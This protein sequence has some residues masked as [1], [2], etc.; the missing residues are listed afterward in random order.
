[1]IL[2]ICL[3][4]GFKYCYFL[5]KWIHV[6]LCNTSSSI[7]TVKW[8]QLLL[9]PTNNS[10][11]TGNGTVSVNTT[12]GQKDPRINDNE[13][14]STFSKVLKTKASLTDSL[15]TCP[16]HSLCQSYPFVEIQST[17]STNPADCAVRKLVLQVISN[18]PFGHLYQINQS[19][20]I[21]NDKAEKFLTKT[22]RK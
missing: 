3:H 13:G 4:N 22:K 18:P 14:Y 17:Y 2:I 12:P 9:F 5:L 20:N 10:I 16:E 6:F 7:C 15:V 8:F 19:L 11:W 21:Y 1:M